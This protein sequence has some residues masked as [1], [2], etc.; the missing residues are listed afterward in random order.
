MQFEWSAILQLVLENVFRLAL[1]VLVPFAL[2][3]LQKKIELTK[4]KL[5]DEWWYAV[6]QAVRLGV[7]AVEQMKLAGMISAE[8]GRAKQKA[9][10]IAERYLAERGVNVNLAVIADMIE[11][12]VAEIN[13]DKITKDE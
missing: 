13:W 2:Q 1:L 10:D 9:I 7:N 6:D 5:G 8:A 11:A 3:W 4:K 12:E